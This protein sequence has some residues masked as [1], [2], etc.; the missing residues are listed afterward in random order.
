MRV[1]DESVIQMRA[2]LNRWLD[3]YIHEIHTTFSHSSFLYHSRTHMDMCHSYKTFASTIWNKH[4]TNRLENKQ[5]TKQNG[6]PCEQ[7]WSW[8][9][10]ANMQCGHTFFKSP[11]L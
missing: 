1:G 8:F 3:P 2:A 7:N 11:P 6:I 5:K 9:M 4:T 10:L